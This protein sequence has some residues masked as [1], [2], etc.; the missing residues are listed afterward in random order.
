[1]KLRQLQPAHMGRRSFLRSIAGVTASMLLGDSM[2]F[3]SS[4]PLREHDFVI[5]NG[6]VLT[7][8]DV[9][10]HPFRFESMTS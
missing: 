6:W 8:E 2:L 5:V 1:M 9:A 10:L 7:R 4:I 3:A